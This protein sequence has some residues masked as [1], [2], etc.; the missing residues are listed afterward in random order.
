MKTKMARVWN[1]KHA[2]NPASLMLVNPSQQGA[3]RQM[4]KQTALAPAPRVITLVPA[5]KR[6]P[7]RPKVR[8]NPSATGL[9]VQGLFSA[10]GAIVTEFVIGFVPVQLT[11]LVSIAGKAA[12]GI[13]LATLSER[14]S[15]LRPYATAIGLGGVA[16]G[17]VEA[18]RL[19]VPRLR[20]IAGF[21]AIQIDPAALT[22]AAQ[23]ASSP[24]A[25]GAAAQNALAG[26]DHTAL[27]Q[28]VF[29]EQQ[30]MGQLVWMPQAA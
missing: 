25:V 24:V 10:V 20:G 28:L 29:M 11:P 8:R 6:N 9:V 22:A 14:V 15:F 12:I 3:S 18:I 21:T 7:H 17:A 30:G 4:K 5:K 2:D 19:A 16:A 1:G 26:Y 23:N 27:G 13:G